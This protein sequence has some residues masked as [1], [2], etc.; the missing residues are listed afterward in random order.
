MSS[1]LSKAKRSRSF[2]GL[3]CRCSSRRCATA[4]EM[5]ERGTGRYTTNGFSY[6]AQH[7][8]CDIAEARSRVSHTIERMSR[9]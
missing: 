3:I 8:S 6:K 2:D 4:S 5:S 9:E 1:R 7:G